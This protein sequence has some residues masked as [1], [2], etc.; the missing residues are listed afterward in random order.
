MEPGIKT[1]KL[2]KVQAQMK[3]ENFCFCFC[4]QKNTRTILSILV[5]QLDCFDPWTFDIL[6]SADRY[7]D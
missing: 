7:H 2:L 1:V 5:Y 4:Y 3:N 6:F